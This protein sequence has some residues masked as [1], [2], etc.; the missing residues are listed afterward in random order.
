M[1]CKDCNGEMSIYSKE[2][3][4]DKEHYW[5]THECSWCGAI[6]FEEIDI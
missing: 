2:L 4:E 6:L 5:V 3:M 1:N